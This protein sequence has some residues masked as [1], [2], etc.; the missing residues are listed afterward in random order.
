MRI[1]TL[2][3]LRSAE[4]TILDVMDWMKLIG[5]MVMYTYVIIIIDLID[6]V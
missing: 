6:P 4:A 1:T 2:P 5:T 3:G